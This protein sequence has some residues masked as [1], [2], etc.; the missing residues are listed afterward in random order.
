MNPRMRELERGS[1]TGHHPGNAGGLLD[2]PALRLLPE[3]HAGSLDDRCLD[4]LG[5]FF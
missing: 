1:A 5:R 3:G 4:F 2:D